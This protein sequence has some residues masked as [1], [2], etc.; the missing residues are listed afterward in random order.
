MLG[1]VI[2]KNV[3]IITIVNK[4][5][6]LLILNVN[7]CISLNM[8]ADDK[9]TKKIIRKG[10][11]L[12]VNKFRIPNKG[13]IYIKEYKITT[14]LIIISLLYFF[15]DSHSNVPPIAKKGKMR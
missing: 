3:K 8:Y 14:V 7:I 1:V 13:T 6:I 11:H 2:I 9:I 12:S 10:N 4:A 5:K 15:K